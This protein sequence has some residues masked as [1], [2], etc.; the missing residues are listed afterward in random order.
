MYVDVAPARKI[1]SHCLLILCL[2]NENAFLELRL[3]NLEKI[4]RIKFSYLIFFEYCK[5]SRWQNS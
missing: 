3:V 2:T 5:N 1:G 4:F